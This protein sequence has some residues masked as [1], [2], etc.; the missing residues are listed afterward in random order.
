[1]ATVKLKGIITSIGKPIAFGTN[2]KQKV[3]FVISETEGNYPNVFK[4]ET[5]KPELLNGFGNGD[6]VEVTA[7]VKG[8]EWSKDGKTGVIVS[9]NA[10][11]NE[12]VVLI[13]KAT[14]PAT[15]A[16]DGSDLPF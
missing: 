4:I 3:E 9:L 16:E 6:L 2:G 5:I 11:Q 13:E 7:D 1:M 14:V 15:Q 12:S 8:R 10:W